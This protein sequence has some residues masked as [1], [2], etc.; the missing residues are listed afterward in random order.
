M[1]ITKEALKQLIKE[2]LGETTATGMDVTAGTVH[3]VRVPAELKLVHTTLRL[4]L[5]ELRNV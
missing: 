4:I 2:E 5:E 1:K 3:D